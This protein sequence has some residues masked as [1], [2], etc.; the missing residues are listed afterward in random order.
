MSDAQDETVA[1]EPAPRA[2]PKEKEGHDRVEVVAAILLGIAGALTAF[3]AYKAALT[4]G[5]ALKGYTESAKSTSDANSSY[6][7]YSQTYYADQQLFR[8]YLLAAN[9]DPEVGLGLRALFF[10]DNLEAATTS[11]ENLPEDERPATALDVDAY[12]ETALEEYNEFSADAE[13]QFTEAAKADSA[14]DKFEQA[15]VFLAIS[16]F[17]AGVASLFKVQGVRYAALIGSALV[18]VP[19]IMAML[20]GQ[21]ALG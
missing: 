14:G 17:L 15:S 11:W 8:D 7:D 9:D 4:D 2:K 13:T 10:D 6:D 20:D 21:S 3:S 18:I 16:L 5:D 12:Q 19:G 1:P